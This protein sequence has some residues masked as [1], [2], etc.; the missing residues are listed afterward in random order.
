MGVVDTIGYDKFP[1][2]GSSLGRAVKVYFNYRS[3][4]SIEGVCVRGDIEKPFE[5]IFKLNDGRFIRDTECQ[6]PIKHE[7]VK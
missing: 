7:V 2:Q 6:Y 4:K 3:S 1:R 5:T